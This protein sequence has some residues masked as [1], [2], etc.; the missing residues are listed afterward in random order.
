MRDFWICFML[1]G[2]LWGIGQIDID[3]KNIH[4]DIN[5]LINAQR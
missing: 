2:I 3:L 1:F 4:S 5:E